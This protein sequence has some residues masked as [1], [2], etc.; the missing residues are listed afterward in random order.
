MSESD[1]FALAAYVHL[2]LRLRLG[3]VVD[4][5]WLV[6]DATYAR[7]IRALCAAQDGR[8]FVECVA[9]LDELLAAIL[10]D[11]TPA[12]RDLVDIDLCL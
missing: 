11:G 8:Q 7:E 12:P 10:A 5:E 1:R 9:Q 3:R 4:S 6:K 2:T